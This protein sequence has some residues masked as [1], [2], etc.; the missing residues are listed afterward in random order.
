MHVLPFKV[1]NA[2]A[3]TKVKNG[4]VIQIWGFKD[5]LGKYE[6]NFPPQINFIELLDKNKP[7]TLYL[8]KL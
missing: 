5:L 2:L 7:K 6:Y 4:D 1:L 8:V 3:Q